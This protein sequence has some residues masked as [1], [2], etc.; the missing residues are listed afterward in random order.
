MNIELESIGELLFVVLVAATVVV[1]FVESLFLK[2]LSR[3][4]FRTPLGYLRAL[5]AT[6]ICLIGAWFVGL[7]TVGCSSGGISAS[8]SSTIGSVIIRSIFYGKMLKNRDTAEPFGFWRGV[9]L[10]ICI[11]VIWTGIVLA[12]LFYIMKI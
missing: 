11:S 2:A 4:L 6:W 9:T 1:S 10:T 3:V 5:C 12:I 7:I 8:A